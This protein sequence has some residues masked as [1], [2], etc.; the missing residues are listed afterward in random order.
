M[1]FDIGISCIIFLN[2]FKIPEVLPKALAEGGTKFFLSRCVGIN[3]FPDIKAW[4]NTN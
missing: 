4:E 2:N 3:N 1:L